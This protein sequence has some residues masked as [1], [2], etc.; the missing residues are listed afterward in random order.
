M[1]DKVAV[2]TAA[3]LAGEFYARLREHGEADRALVQATA[4]WA[5]EGDKTVPALYARLG[6]VAGVQ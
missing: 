2:K 5:K 4:A 1:T 3:A 6:W